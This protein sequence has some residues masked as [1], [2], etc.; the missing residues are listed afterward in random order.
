MKSPSV[1]DVK[2]DQD[3]PLPATPSH[4]CTLENSQHN[5]S[6]H[7]DTSE[8]PACDDDEDARPRSLART[9]L[10]PPVLPLKS[11]ENPIQSPLQSPTIADSTSLPQ[12]PFEC[13]S[14]YNGLPS[15][16]L[17][18][19]PSIASFHHRPIVPSSEIPAIRLAD[20]QDEWAVKLGHFN[21]TIDPE[22]YA[23]AA[24]AST[25]DCLRLHAHWEIANQRY[26]KHLARA[27]EIHGTTS[28]I[29]RYT[30]DK[31]ATIDAI[32]K[33]NYEQGIASI[34]HDSQEAVQ[35]YRQKLDVSPTSLAKLPSIN[36]PHSDEK[37]PQANENGI[38]GRMEQVRPVAPLRASRKRVFWKFLQGVLPSSVAFGRSQA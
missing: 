32:W 13:P 18:T 19:K 5:S 24:P 33:H 8:I 1:L 35:A 3:V 14:P 26:V 28:T 29:Y 22:P 23:I 12:S 9:P 37:F 34:P 27:A 10:L 2:T 36:G 25:A 20:P 16:P 4:S 30:Q 38:V 17:S 15:P 6:D 31:W 21:F 11:D 7:V